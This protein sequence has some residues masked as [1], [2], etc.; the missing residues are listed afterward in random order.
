MEEIKEVTILDIRD[1]PSATPGREGKL[2][3][4][5]TY[6]IDPTH[7]YVISIPKEEFNEIRLKEEIKK[8][9]EEKQKWIGKKLSLI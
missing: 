4:F 1:M 5:V 7:T 9:L 2:D 8:D 3:V 6:Q